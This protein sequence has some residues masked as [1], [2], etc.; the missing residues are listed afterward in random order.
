MVEF[1]ASAYMTDTQLSRLKWI[2]FLSK[3]FPPEQRGMAMGFF[4]MGQTAGPIVGTVIGGYLTEYLSCA[5]RV[6]TCSVS[7]GSTSRVTWA[8][9][10]TGACAKAALA[11][12]PMVPRHASQTIM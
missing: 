11:I 2:P 12:W 5:R 1:S 7:R 3:V 4:G 10:T 9:S 8:R 6:W